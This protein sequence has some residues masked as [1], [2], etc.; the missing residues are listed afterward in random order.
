[1]VV[2]LPTG[3]GKTVI[4]AELARRARKQVLVLAHR[5]ELLGQAVEKLRRATRAAIALERG[6]DRAAADAKVLV[7]SLRS[8]HEERLAEFLAGRDFGL[9]IYDECHHA[10]ADDNLRILRALG[11]F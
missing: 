5:E 9:V 6:A 7:A 3:A 1:M 2:C 4:F 11:A 8:L 10:A